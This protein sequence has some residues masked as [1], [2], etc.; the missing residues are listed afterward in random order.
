MVN[1]ID[2]LRQV[3]LGLVEVPRSFTTP[4]DWKPPESF[5][6]L[7]GVCAID[8]E[9]KDPGI[10]MGRGSSWPIIGEG[11]VVGCAFRWAGGKVY[12]PLKHAAGNI[13]SE[14]SFWLW[15]RVQAQKPDVYFVMANAPYDTGW[16]KRVGV[17]P[18]RPP[19]DVQVMAFL[20]DE[21]RR[22]YSLANL[23][24]EFLHRDKGTLTLYDA[25]RALHIRK[26]MENM[27][28]LPA[29]IVEPY[30]LD[31]ADLTYELYHYFH[32]KI[33]AEELGNVFELETDCNLVAVDMRYVGVRVDQA[34]LERLGTL[35]AMRRDAELAQIARISG[36]HMQPFEN[37]AAVRALRGENTNV[38]L[39]HTD[40]GRESVAK[41]VLL[42][43]NSPVSNAILAARKY[44]KAISTFIAST[45]SF[46]HN[47]R[48]HAEFHPTRNSKSNDDYFADDSVSGAGSGR[49]ASTNPNLQNIP[50]RDPDIGPFIR[51]CYIP[52]EGERWVKLDYAS[53]EP[54]LTVHFAN[55]VIYNGRPLRGAAE[56]VERFNKNPLTDLHGECAT[57]MGIER[58]PAK[59]INLAL[60]YGMQG[61]S[62]CR[63]L[64]LPTKWIKLRNGRDLEVAGD[65]GERLLAKHFEAVP[66]IKG[67]ADV[68]KAQGN[69][70]G[71]VKTISGRRL[72][73]ERYPDGNYARLHSALNKVIQGSA[74]DQMKMALVALRK[75]GLLCPL[76]VHDEADRSIP[77]GVE[78]ERIV[79]RMVEIMEDVVQITVPMIAEA[80]TGDSWGACK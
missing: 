74:G 66:F 52:E 58:G 44:D 40:M 32:P 8:F 43:I 60:A 61:A 36:V 70:H 77:M 21:H 65:E 22:S 35:F 63:S 38:Q 69:T 56:M 29:W 42:N 57:L 20:L 4:A 16:M 30:A 33:M 53:Q 17:T 64:G 14:R 31:D 34:K 13:E 7:F 5:P 6:E 15:L 1:R 67:L 80:K 25:A 24:K 18:H 19:M 79:D 62:L 47:G 54:R 46:I 68:A 59:V 3:D 49:F 78:G 50:A 2:D 45:I 23:S 48:I 73:F 26:P 12:F 9:T 71:Y 27:D 72:R 37:E 76:T 75:A 39:G 28:K 51:A 11:F 41:S 55:L 10:A